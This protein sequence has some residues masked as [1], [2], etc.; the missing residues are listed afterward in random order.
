MR[1]TILAL[2]LASAASAQ[3]APVN[4][5]ITIQGAQFLSDE[6]YE[7]QPAVWDPSARLVVSF[8]GEDINGDSIITK[9]ELT[10]LT[11]VG[12][13]FFNL[14]LLQ[15]SDENFSYYIPS[16]SYRNPQDYTIYGYFNYAYY[17]PVTEYGESVKLTQDTQKWGWW[18]DNGDT[19]VWVGT[20]DSVVTVS[21]VPE[22]ATIGML[23]LGL[24]IVGLAARRRR[25]SPRS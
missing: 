12:G 9:N 11:A 21:A 13:S 2:V 4:V 24:S 8:S 15:P 7:T 19:S 23:A 1:K 20:S 18:N 25:N 10:S 3:A 5:S 6:H 14:N 22:P 17:P 16:F